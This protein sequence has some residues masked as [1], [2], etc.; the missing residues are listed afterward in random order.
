MP[1]EPDVKDWTWVLRERCPE[2]GFDPAAVTTADLPDRIRAAIAAIHPVLHDADA[3]DR[4]DDATW[5]KL[6][7]AAHVRDVCR[8]MSERLQLMLTE[9][10]P[11]FANWDQDATAVEERYNEQDPA[12]VAAELDLA[13]SALAAAFEAVQEP[14]ESRHGRRSNGSRFTVATLGAYA[15]HDLEHHVWDVSKRT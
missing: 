11:V 2:C 9:D 3:R 13:G 15:L 6:E 7:Y 5:S 14:D 8:T 10:D 1:I 12:R 4:P